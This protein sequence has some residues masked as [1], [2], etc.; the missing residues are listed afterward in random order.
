MNIVLAVIVLGVI[1]VAVV[2]DLAAVITWIKRRW[3]G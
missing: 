1:G 3:H 2:V